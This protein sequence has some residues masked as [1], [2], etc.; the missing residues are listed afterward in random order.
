MTSE[1]LKQEIAEQKSAKPKDWREGQFVFNY[2]EQ[3]YGGLARAVQFN[4]NVDC[5]YNDSEI[6]K[7]IDCCVKR[8][9]EYERR[10]K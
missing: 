7:F 3:V 10:N 5:F 2:I 1:E 8:I 9:N 6:D 4:D